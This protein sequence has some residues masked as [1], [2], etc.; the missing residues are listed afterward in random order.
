MEASGAMTGRTMRREGVRGRR[1]SP[2]G[3]SGATA[4]A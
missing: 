1:L 2:A 4:H 3:L